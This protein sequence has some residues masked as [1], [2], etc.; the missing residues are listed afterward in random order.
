A[1]RCSG[2]GSHGGE[3][4]TRAAAVRRG[5]TSAR[6]SL[7]F[8]SRAVRGLRLRARSRDRLPV[9]GMSDR[10]T[11]RSI[12]IVNRGEAAMRCLRAVTS[13]RARGRSDL[14]AIVL[15]T[16]V[17][18]DTPFVRHA[19]IAVELRHRGSAVTAYLDR[20]GLLEAISRTGAD[21]VWP[22]WGFLAEDPTFAERVER[23]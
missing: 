3:R 13:L 18:R 21:A 14:T 5:S 15:Y 23:A 16:D 10:R 12:A 1:G 17:D 11:I 8:P 9:R 22:G 2:E 19:D 4:A 7:A 20:E 6:G